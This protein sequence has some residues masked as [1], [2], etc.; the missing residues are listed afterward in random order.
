[1]APITS[2]LHFDSTSIFTF[3]IALELHKD[4]GKR[5]VTVALNQQIGTLMLRQ[6][7]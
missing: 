4:S 7:I 5:G 2:S 6:G 1:M 3:I